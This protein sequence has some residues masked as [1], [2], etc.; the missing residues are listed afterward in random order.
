MA[1]ANL[2]LEPMAQLVMNSNL[3]DP[4]TLKHQLIPGIAIPNIC[5]ELYMYQNWLINK[6]TRVMTGENTYG[7]DPVFLPL[8]SYARE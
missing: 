8:N 5:V 2:H 1:I 6:V 4:T 7:T 3:V